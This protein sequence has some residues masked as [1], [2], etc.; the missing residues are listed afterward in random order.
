MDTIIQENSKQV[1]AYDEFITEAWK[2][3]KGNDDLSA[4]AMRT[5]LE[6]PELSQ[7]LLSVFFYYNP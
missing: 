7:R 6:S 1:A 3:G 5:M 2:V 4:Q